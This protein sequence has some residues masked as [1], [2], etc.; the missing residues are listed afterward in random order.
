[1]QGAIRV[2]VVD[3]SA[4]MRKRISDLLATDPGVQVVGAARDGLDALDQVGRLLPDVVTLDVEMPGLNGL[5]A[6]ARIMAN[7]PRPVVMVSSLTQRGTDATVRALAMGAVDFVPKPSGPVSLDLH[8]V[9]DELVRKVKAAARVP[10]GSLR[11]EARPAGA[12]VPAASP[13]PGGRRIAG[14]RALTGLVVVASSTGG[15]G[16]LYRLLQ[17]LPPGLKA[18]LLVVQH[19]PP[20]FTRSL[21]AH[22]DQVS[23]LTVREAAAGDRPAD[24]LALVAPGGTHLVLTPAGN[25]QLDSGPPRHGVRPAADVTL[26][27]IPESLWRR[28]LVVVLTGMGMDGARGA[29][30]LH[31]RGA[32]VWA[33]DE[34]SSVVFGMPRAVAELGVARRVG[35]PEQLSAWLVERLGG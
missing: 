1:M 16:A 11:S 27:S 9:R 24:G 17:P 5:E 22:L 14:S 34:A 28:T 23:R 12:T 20:A 19:M 2:L 35:S 32:E 10:V 6:L 4:F 31:D 15:P 33:Q 18:G 29:K 7:H 3:D 25:V 13:D 8:R 26:D 30:R 21:A